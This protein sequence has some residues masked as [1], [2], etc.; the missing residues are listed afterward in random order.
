MSIGN[1]RTKGQ[2]VVEETVQIQ[3][4]QAGQAGQVGQKPTKR[5]IAQEEL[6]LFS[7]AVEGSCLTKIALVED[8]KRK[9]V[10]SSLLLFSFSTN[11]LFLPFPFFIM[12]EIFHSSF[13]VASERFYSRLIYFVGHVSL[14]SSQRRKLIDACN[15]TKLMYD[16]IPQDPQ[17]RH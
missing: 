2:Q 4:G 7:A 12:L 13:R 14:V 17:R 6:P 1:E 5:F 16:Q 9:W 10:I 3:A 11:T 15:T 8:L